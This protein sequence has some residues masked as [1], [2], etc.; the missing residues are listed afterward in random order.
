MTDLATHL[1]ISNDLKALLR[2]AIRDE[3][4]KI[5]PFFNTLLEDLMFPG[6]VIN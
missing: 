2:F 5:H 3:I 1:L 6:L 4:F